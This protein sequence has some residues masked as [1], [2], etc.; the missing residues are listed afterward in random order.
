MKKWDDYSM[1]FE[2]DEDYLTMKISLDEL[3]RLFHESPHNFNGYST[4]ATIREGKEQNFAEKVI[5]VL[6][7]DAPYE[8]D[9][10]VWSQPFTYVFNEII[11]SAADD[12]LEYHES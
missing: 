2:L 4:Y 12:I 6:R 9:D 3:K 8:A 5:N 1:I 7:D 10:L 11:E